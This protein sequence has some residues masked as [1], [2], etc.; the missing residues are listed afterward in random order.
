MWQVAVWDI[1]SGH[2]DRQLQGAAA[3]MLMASLAQELT[4]SMRHLS[5]AQAQ[6]HAPAAATGAS[7]VSTSVAG[8]HTSTAA[9]AGLYGLASNGYGQYHNSSVSGSK[10]ASLDIPY[11]SSQAASSDGTKV[12]SSSGGVDTAGGFV[13]RLQ[14]V[15]HTGPL[16][17]VP[18]GKQDVLLLDV[19]VQQLMLQLEAYSKQQKR[20]NSR[21]RQQNTGSRS[22]SIDIDS[23]TASARASRASSLDLLGLLQG[24]SPAGAE[25]CMSVGAS[26]A[27]S[28][29]TSPQQQQQQYAPRA[30]ALAG[31]LHALQGTAAAMPRQG[32][33]ALAVG[34]A[35]EQGCMQGAAQ[36]GVGTQQQLVHGRA[37]M[38]PAVAAALQGL[39]LLHKWG[40]EP[41]LDKQLV[42]LLGQ[43][44]GWPDSGLGQLLMPSS[45]TPRSMSPTTPTGPSA[46]A[47]ATTAAAAAG[48]DTDM[49]SGTLPAEAQPLQLLM[50]LQHL[51]EGPA[52]GSPVLQAAAPC[53]TQ[54]VLLSPRCH[55]AVIALPTAHSSGG[56][57][58]RGSSQQQ[59]EFAVE[60]EQRKSSAA[61][62]GARGHAAVGRPSCLLLAAC[63]SLRSCR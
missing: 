2:M 62:S 53:L 3:H 50:Q 33:V 38:V 22:N 23:S 48:M 21:Q 46:G 10:R 60:Q 13:P 51:L 45:S 34:A 28:S 29:R 55:A 8:Q 16:K 58:D 15:H 36:A 40:L 12:S 5:R 20:E 25:G 27:N 14:L 59:E 35:A 49:H 17:P 4:S 32:S 24:G 52:S 54:E 41:Q 18:Y 61:G 57:T 56:F 39:C 63:P 43:L 9:A 37:V 47:V 44:Q 6:P 42:L 31:Q 7:A 1:Y 19:N 30:G 11:S 26:A